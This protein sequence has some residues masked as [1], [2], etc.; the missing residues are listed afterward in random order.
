MRI[1]S[2]IAVGGQ[3]IPRQVGLADQ[4]ADS[5]GAVRDELSAAI[6]NVKHVE[7]GLAVIGCDD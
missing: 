4:W 2:Q 1:V 5:D 3:D 7:L 6:A